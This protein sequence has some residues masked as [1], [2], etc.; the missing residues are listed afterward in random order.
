MLTVPVFLNI[1]KIDPTI[2]I[3]KKL[4]REKITKYL[5]VIYTIFSNPKR[6]SQKGYKIAKKKNINIT[7]RMQKTIK[8]ALFLSI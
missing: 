2:K 8:G 7:F 6:Y 1:D 5:N 4:K 3:G